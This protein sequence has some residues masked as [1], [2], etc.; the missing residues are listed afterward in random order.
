M[1]ECGELKF[2]YCVTHAVVFVEPPVAWAL[3]VKVSVVAGATASRG[4][5][6][7]L[8]LLAKVSEFWIRSIGKWKLKRP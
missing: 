8:D 2:K 4:H 7:E 6:C 3:T 5:R 1:E